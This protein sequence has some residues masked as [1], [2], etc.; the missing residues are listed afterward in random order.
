MTRATAIRLFCMLLTFAAR[1][2]MTQAQASES[3]HCVGL[4]QKFR[5][6]VANGRT[7]QAETLLADSLAPVASR[8]QH[9]C[10][11]LILSRT[12]VQMAVSG[13]M[14]EAEEF[15]EQSVHVLGEN[16]SPDDVVF[17]RPFHILASA[18]F[19]RGEVRKARQAFKRMKTIR[20]ERPEERAMLSGFSATLLTAEGRYREAESEYLLAVHAWEQAG[21]GDMADTGT[22]L[23][24]LGSL[25][26]REHRLD[27][28][29]RVLD[30]AFGIFTSA[31]DTV[32]LDLFKLLEVRAA[33]HVKLQEWRE[34][35]QDLREAV[36]MTDRLPG[37]DTGML[38]R[39][40]ADYAYVL[41]KNHR[42]REA[43]SIEARA[44]V[45]HRQAITNMVIDTTELQAHAKSATK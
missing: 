27:D 31:K 3:A 5:E 16:F 14:D 30:L 44:A 20:I 42:R 19:E 37:L 17:F 24:A 33:M 26:I 40:L 32:P 22:V 45:L 29:R 18:R 21:R 7:T 12:A 6:E 38:G 11:G 28:A 39:A 36:A 35:E 10:A 43:R 15:A 4:D 9:S 13:R 25:Y 1:H 2:A 8:A 41:R 23:N 34:A